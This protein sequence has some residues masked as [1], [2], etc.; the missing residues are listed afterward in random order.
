MSV[1]DIGVL[2]YPKTMRNS[3]IF[4]V[5]LFV[6]LSGLILFW[7]GTIQIP[8]FKSLDDR[9]VQS[10]TK[11]YDRTGQVLLYDVHQNIKRTVIPFQDMGVYIKNATVAIE[12]AEFYQHGGIRLTSIFRAIFINILKG[13]F[14]Q[15]GSTITQQIVKNTVLTNEKTISRKLKEWILSVKVDQELPKDEILGIYLN[16]APYGGNIYGI[17]EATRAFFG[18]EPKDLSLAEASYLAAIPNAPTY[19]SPYGKNRDK[20]E[21]RKS[22]VLNRMKTL[23]F[24]SSKEYEKAKNENVSFLPQEPF[25]IRAPHFVFFVKEYLEQ[26][27]GKEAALGGGLKVTT[28][29]DYNLQ[30]QAED[31]VLKYAKENEVKFKGKNAAMVAIDP[32]TGQ[33]LTMVGSRDYFDKEIDG[34][35]NV[36]LAKRQPGSA[37]KPFVYVTAFNKGFTPDTVVF[38]LP[39]E[40][41]TTC[42][43]YGKALPGQKQDDCYM[44]ENYDGKF[45]GPI[46]LRNAL[47]QSVNIPAVKMIY[48]SGVADSIKTARGLG[49]TTLEDPNRYGLTLV[50]GG[51]EVTLLD[52]TSAYGVFAAGGERHSY[53]KILKVEDADGKVLEEYKNS[54]QSVLSKNTALMIS[55]ILSDNKAKEPL[56]GPNSPI[57]FYDRSVASKT[58]TTNDYRDAWIVGYSPSLVVGAWAGN[59]DN[60][61]MEKKTS[62]LIVAPLWSEFIRAA[63]KDMPKENFEEPVFTD[64]SQQTKPVIA[65][66][67]QGNDGFLI[68]KISGKLASVYTP[69]ETLEKKVVTN[70]HS[71][72]FWV[73]KENPLGQKPERPEDDPQFLRWE[74]P[75]QKWWAENGYKYPITTLADKPILIDD[76][77]TPEKKPN[78]AI[79]EPNHQKQYTLDQKVGVLIQNNSFYP[80]KKIDIFINGE[81]LDSVKREPFSYSFTPR[82]LSQIGQNNEIKIVAQDSVYNTS[83]ATEQ[84]GVLVNN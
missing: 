64:D 13:Q 18:K 17:K 33:I 65:G 47:A 10:S 60:S 44:P 63:L 45:R 53:Q 72:L 11:I 74:I 81:Y 52:M 57:Y 14:S 77:H 5:S 66:F 55:S 22:F 59:N 37:F 2:C 76:V 79:I 56:Y 28:T 25:G 30:K 32:K 19:Y 6:L 49:I 73:S 84:F 31:I 38:D 7:V 29:L 82:E 83:S 16:E 15:G 67:W 42:D 8:D 35:F 46:S 39:T 23:G 24:V 51:G 9:L 27:Y 41:Q 20:L 69:K 34:N 75:V 71:I 70:V 68:D 43:P 21:E 36:A 54:S 1:F 61:P 80:L 78:I 26:K 58:G 12:D 40:F 48:L 50:L 3:L 62:G 4:L